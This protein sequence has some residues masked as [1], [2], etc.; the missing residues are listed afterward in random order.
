M[1]VRGGNFCEIK[2]SVIQRGTK[3]PHLSYL[4]DSIVGEDC[5]FGAGTIVAN[6]RLDSRTIRMKIKDKIVD[7]GL[8]KLGAVIGD[9]V[10]T[11]INVSIMPGVK[12]GGGALI[13]PGC[14]IYD[15]VEPRA[16]VF[17]KQ[18]LIIKPP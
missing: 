8:R 16:R 10:K 5:N 13:G 6:L 2:N 18:E 1:G 15:D 17:C 11:G 4:G 9:G 14:V 7:T 12:I 3:I